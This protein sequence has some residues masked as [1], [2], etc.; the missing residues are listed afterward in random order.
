MVRPRM[1]A[2][3]KTQPPI[4]ALQTVLT[5]A[6]DMV[7][8]LLGDA[9]VQRLLD[10]FT[11]FPRADREP[12]LQVLE[13]DSAWRRI[14]ERTAD[15]TGIHVAPNPHASLYVHVIGQ[16]PDAP[17]RDADVIRSGVAT[18]VEILPLLFQDAVHA[19]WLEAARDVAR[20]AGAEART[21]AARMASEILALVAEIEADTADTT[22]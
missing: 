2:P 6:R 15:A 16:G 22:R 12:I 1:L 11:A 18:F 19:Q 21:L 3:H 20:S 8:A 14:V 17:G 9:S 10:A 7:D 5:A 13:K 4:D